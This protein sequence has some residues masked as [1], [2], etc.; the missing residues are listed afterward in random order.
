MNRNII[1]KALAF[2]ILAL[3]FTACNDDNEKEKPAYNNLEE[4]IVGKWI[5]TDN[6]S[7]NTEW[8]Y[9]FRN[10]KTGI[11]FEGDEKQPITYH[12]YKNNVTVKA[13]GNGST[14][15]FTVQHINDVEMRITIENDSYVRTLKKT[16]NDHITDNG[17]NNDDNDDDEPENGG[18]TFDPTPLIESNVTATA[19]YSNYFWTFTFKSTLANQL[20]DCRIEFQVRHGNSYSSEALTINDDP[21]VN[22]SSSESVGVLSTTVSYPFYYHFLAAEMLYGSS[23]YTE[24]AAECQDYLNALI[25]LNNKIDSGETLTDEEL[26]LRSNAIREL[27]YN[28]ALARGEYTAWLFVVINDKSYPLTHFT[29]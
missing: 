29:L 10:D 14:Q 3:E 21:L 7:G 8:G 12:T 24:L 26:Q 1:I 28:E 25:S 18:T 15:T 27:D 5:C 16:N 2:I 6:L 19:I 4:M 23:L 11:K 22:R 9:T 20:P 17:G 13:T